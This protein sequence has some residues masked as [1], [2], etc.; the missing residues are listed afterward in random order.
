MQNKR[1]Q[2]QAHQFVTGRLVTALVR[3]EPDQQDTPLRRAGTGTLIGAGLGVA[4][5]L[6]YFVYGLVVRGGNTSW[7][8]PGAIIVA[9]ETGSRFLYLDGTLRPVANYASALLAA[10]EKAKVRSVSANSLREVPHGRPIGIPDAPEVLPDPAR[11]STAPWLVCAAFAANP[12]ETSRPAVALG[13]DTAWPTTQVPDEQAVL[14]RDVNGELHLVWRDRRLRIGGE[15][16]LA[17]LGYASV[18]PLPVDPAWLNAIEPG[19]ALT[20]PQVPGRG[21]A[22][23]TVDGRPT[24]VG[25]IFQTRNAAGAEDYFLMRND[26]LAPL[27]RTELAL[28]QGDPA[29]AQAYQGRPVQPIVISAAGAAQAKRSATGAAP[30]LPGTPPQAVG[31]LGADGR[32]LCLRL[33]MDRAGPIARLV[34]VPRGRLD[35]SRATPKADPRI[36]DLVR[37]P[38]GSG[39][40]IEAQPAP[41]VSSGTRFVLTD[42]GVKYPVPSAEVAALLGYGG[43]TPVPVPTGLLSFLPTGPALDPAAARTELAVPR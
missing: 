18:R 1:D 7:Q 20:S 11:L 30:N 15:A 29:T 4:L 40:L 12:D 13:L 32:T 43:A 42:L 26:G 8:Q 19:P 2:L 17:A 31:D 25:Q 37:V 21:S 5:L 38:P 39:A 36:A 27:S 6:G 23:S 3:G 34:T 24:V 16:V 9:E 41:G 35:L 14:V 10:G 22:G 33:T 28:V